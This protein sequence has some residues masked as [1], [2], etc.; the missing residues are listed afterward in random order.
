M[1]PPPDSKA[2]SDKELVCVIRTF[3]WRDADSQFG[4]AEVLRLSADGSY[5]FSTLLERSG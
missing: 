2:D 5:H 4:D 1:A 3:I